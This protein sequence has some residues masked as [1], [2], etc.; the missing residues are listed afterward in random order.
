M[1]TLSLN[2]KAILLELLLATQ[3]HGKLSEPI[4][5]AVEKAQTLEDVNYSL[6]SA[7]QELKRANVFIVQLIESGTEELRG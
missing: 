3:L 7:I 2:Q 5:Q 4:L 1:T 6:S